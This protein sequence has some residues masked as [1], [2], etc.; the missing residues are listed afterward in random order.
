MPKKVEGI[1]LWAAMGES[2]ENAQHKSLIFFMV[3]APVF[4]VGA[5]S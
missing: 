3:V 4:P 2:S 1:W 5:T